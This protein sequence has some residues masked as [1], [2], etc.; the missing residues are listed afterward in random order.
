MP[1]QTK[2]KKKRLKSATCGA[3]S[4]VFTLCGTQQLLT[5]GSVSHT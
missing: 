1:Q 2:K 3:A 4:E 5:A